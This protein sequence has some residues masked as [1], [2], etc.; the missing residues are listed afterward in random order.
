MIISK[1]AS[2]VAPTRLQLLQ[3]STYLFFLS[4]SFITSETSGIRP[5]TRPHKWREDGTKVATRRTSFETWKEEANP[6]ILP[7]HTL[8]LEPIQ[9]LHAPTTVIVPV[10]LFAKVGEDHDTALVVSRRRV[11]VSIKRDTPICTVN[12]V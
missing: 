7:N 1:Q 10:F 8:N 9:M 3:R 4:L 12:H 5:G 11:E 2:R 6:S